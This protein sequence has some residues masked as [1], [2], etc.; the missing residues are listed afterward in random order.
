VSLVNGLGNSEQRKQQAVD[1]WC[2]THG[3]DPPWVSNNMDLY[4]V[5]LPRPPTLLPRKPMLSHREREDR[6]D[7]LYRKQQKNESKKKN[8]SC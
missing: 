5:F 6:T 8:L 7:K 1:D 4:G 3:L 2:H